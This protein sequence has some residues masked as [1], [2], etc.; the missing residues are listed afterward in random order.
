MSP[1]SLLMQHLASPLHF[2]NTH[3][4]GHGQPPGGK[5]GMLPV[6]VAGEN[7]GTQEG[8]EKEA[9][10][11][12]SA[13]RSLEALSKEIVSTAIS[14]VVQNTLSALLCPNEASEDPSLAEFL[15]TE[16]PPGPLET[17]TQPTNLTDNTTVT[18]ATEHGA[19]EHLDEAYAKESSAGEEVP[20][21]TLV[22]TEEEDFE[23]LDQ[24]ELEMMDE[25]LDLYSDRQVAGGAPDTSS[26]DQS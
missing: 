16:T 15:P 9:A 1:A 22:P 20:D 6:S 8:E 2:V 11:A 23:L 24:S 18:T 26:Q 10:V 7:A 19:Y 21:D 12:Q 13:Q 3:F 5:D 25:V 14:T 4:N 17:F